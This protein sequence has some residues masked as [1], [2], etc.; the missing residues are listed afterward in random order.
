[1]SDARG[2]ERRGPLSIEIGPGERLPWLEAIEEEDAPRGPGAGRLIGAL[3]LALLALGAIIGGGYWLTTR[4]GEDGNGEI[5]AAPKGDYKVPAPQEGGMEIEGRGDTAYAASEGADPQG[6]IDLGA[7]PEEPVTP[8]RP[9]PPRAPASAT[10]PTPAPKAEPVQGAEPAPAAPA[11]APEP[12]PPPAG[13]GTVQL[14]AFNNEAQAN[15]AWKTLSGRFSTLAGLTQ[16]VQ[17]AVV[18]GKT[19][20]RLRADTGSGATARELC[21][22]LKV[23]GERCLVVGR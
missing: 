7:L 13:P 15:A 1:M 18:N 23:A 9:A 8:V 19:V 22:R 6:T 3:L 2:G 5:I 11:E 21:G 10:T 17:R 20:Y 4:G 16:S 14:G 12:A